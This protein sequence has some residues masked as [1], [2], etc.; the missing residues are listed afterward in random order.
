MQLALQQIDNKLK[1]VEFGSMAAQRNCGGKFITAIATSVAACNVGETRNGKMSIFQDRVKDIMV[2]FLRS[3]MC[4]LRSFLLRC[5]PQR[6]DPTATRLCMICY[7]SR[8]IFASKPQNKI[9]RYHCSAARIFS[10]TPTVCREMAAT[11]YK[12]KAHASHRLIRA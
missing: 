3:K 12:T 1:Q 9:C 11:A 2:S 10:Q 4:Q 6:I 5:L 7:Q 8:L